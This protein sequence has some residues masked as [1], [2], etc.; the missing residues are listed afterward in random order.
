MCTCAGVLYHFSKSVCG[1]FLDF[2]SFLNK[3]LAQTELRRKRGLSARLS[4]RNAN[5]SLIVF[6]WHCSFL[7]LSLSSPPLLQDLATVS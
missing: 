7:T 6:R 4:G 1:V 5:G 3:Y 2:Y